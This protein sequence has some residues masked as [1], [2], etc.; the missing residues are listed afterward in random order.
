VVERELQGLGPAPALEVGT[1][2]SGADEDREGDD[3]TRLDLVFADAADG[4]GLGR[5]A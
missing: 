4:A 5:D 3:A 1:D 2:E